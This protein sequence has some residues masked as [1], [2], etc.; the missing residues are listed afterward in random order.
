MEASHLGAVAEVLALSAAM[1]PI[2]ADGKVTSARSGSVY[3]EP[4]VP[5]QL[6]G[7]FENEMTPCTALGGCGLGSH[8]QRH[9]HFRKALLRRAPASHLRRRRGRRDRAQLH[10]RDRA[11]LPPL[12]SARCGCR[13]FQHVAKLLKAHS[14]VIESRYLV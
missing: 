6:T 5:A 14:A 11:Q 12:L 8:G 2:G 1:I 7:T 3:W 4:S 10:R 9:S 13:G